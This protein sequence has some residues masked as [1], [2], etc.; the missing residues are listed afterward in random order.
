M[1]SRSPVSDAE[2][3]SL[4]PANG[5]ADI[6]I[7]EV[8]PPPRRS[9][10]GAALLVL[11]AAAAA[12]TAIAKLRT[13]DGAPP[14]AAPA[15]APA[16]VTIVVRARPPTATIE[17][18]GKPVGTRSA[19]LRVLPD[20]GDADRYYA[21]PVFRYGG[22]YW[23]FLSP[24]WE[25]PTRNTPEMSATRDGGEWGGA[26]GAAGII[27][28]DDLR[29]PDSQPGQPVGEQLDQHRGEAVDGVGHRPR[30]GGQVGGQGVEGPESQGV[31]VEE[32]Q[33]RH[34][35]HRKPHG[36]TWGRGPTLRRSLGLPPRRNPRLRR[37]P[38]DEGPQGGRRSRISTE[39]GDDPLRVG[40][41]A[42][43]PERVVGIPN[44]R[45]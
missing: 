36:R 17:V 34:R 1:K 8:A 38:R 37:G 11:L 28:V 20:A 33:L 44:G 4:P 2:Q 16:S 27:D 5:D 13:S 25:D 42:P 18:D 22:V 12:G 21:M 39:T 40:R 31:P 7:Q 9:R 23:G 15:S 30:L 32:Y 24:L 6:E 26:G 29:I 14:S 35:L 3:Q 19:T 10:W 41:G 43:P 45:S